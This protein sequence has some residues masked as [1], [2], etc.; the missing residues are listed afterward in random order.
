MH[1]STDQLSVTPDSPS[2]FEYLTISAF[3]KH[4]HDH[5]LSPKKD[6]TLTATPEPN[7]PIADLTQLT[8]SQAELDQLVGVNDVLL[9]DE[10]AD[11]YI[12]LC[13]Y[14][15]TRYQAKR[16]LVGCQ[17]S[18]NSEAI[19]TD[20]IGITGGV[21]VGKSTTARVIQGLLKKVI[22][23]TQLIT[24]DNFLLPNQILENANLMSKKGFPESYDI[25]AL[26]NAIITIAANTAT[27]IT[28]PTYSHTLYDIIPNQH[29]TISQPKILVLEGLNALQPIPLAH[30]HPQSLIDLLNTA[31]YVNAPMTEVRNWYVERFFKFRDTE[32]TKPGSRWHEFAKLNDAETRATALSIYDEINEPNLLHHILPTRKNADFI[33]EKGSDHK[34]MGVHVHAR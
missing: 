34:I 5:S 18:N 15:L 3:A 13:Q 30:D 11:C 17:N 20:I 22:P 31:I 26:I 8:M 16:A 14:I 32:F 10:I 21:A 6:T 25:K 9:V 33:L 7:S 1:T 23:E 24:T 12:P 2:G 28:I 19:T 29:Q 4:L 27:E